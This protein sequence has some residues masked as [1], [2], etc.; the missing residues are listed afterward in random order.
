MNLKKLKLK[1]KRRQRYKK[2]KDR[3]KYSCKE[4]RCKARTWN[5][6]E[7][8]NVDLQESLMA[9]VK[10]IMKKDDWWLGTVDC[11]RP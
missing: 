7:E 9:F 2:C 10:N 4:N 6:G 1:N 11:P 5:S 8:D 3:E